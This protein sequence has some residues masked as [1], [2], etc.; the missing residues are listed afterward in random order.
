MI[1]H[2]PKLSGAEFISH[3]SKIKIK[4]KKAYKYDKTQSLDFI[5]QRKKPCHLAYVSSCI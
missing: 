5:K 4:G 2:L 3:Y 1:E